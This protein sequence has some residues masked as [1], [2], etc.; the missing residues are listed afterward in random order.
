M[1]ILQTD[2]RAT[3]REG[4]EETKGEE[5][6]ESKRPVCPLPKTTL[7]TEEATG[8]SA[9]PLLLI[10]TL[11]IHAAVVLCAAALEEPVP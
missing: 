8:M 9:C 1:P 7:P 11:V 4:K 2:K 3:S 5:M 10:F 6:R